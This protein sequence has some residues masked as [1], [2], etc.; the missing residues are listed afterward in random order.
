MGGEIV[1]FEERHPPIPLK[2]DRPPSLLDNA[3]TALFLVSDD[4]AY[5]SGQ[6]ISS[7]DGGTQARV[8]IWFP[9]DQGGE[10][11]APL[12]V[13]GRRDLGVPAR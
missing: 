9:E 1:A 3:K 11:T 5:T 7:A 6:V 13:P 10:W 12:I 4:A 8:A 2:L